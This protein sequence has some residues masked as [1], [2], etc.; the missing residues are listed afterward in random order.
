M[1]GAEVCLHAPVVMAKFCGTKL[2][3]HSSCVSRVL[4]D[5]DRLSGVAGDAFL[6]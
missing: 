5:I 2:K 1:G 4:R 6:A 3:R